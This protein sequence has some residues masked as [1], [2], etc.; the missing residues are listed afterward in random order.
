MTP[1]STSKATVRRTASRATSVCP[2]ATAASSPSPA[3][4]STRSSRSALS[5]TARAGGVTTP[6][7]SSTTP[8]RATTTGSSVAHRPLAL[9]A[10]QPS[11]LASPQAS[12]MPPSKAPWCSP[13]VS[14]TVMVR[15]C[16]TTPATISPTAWS[17]TPT[18]TT[19]KARATAA[20][21]IV[22]PATAPLRTCVLP[23]VRSTAPSRSS[24]V[25]SPPA[26]WVRSRTTPSQPVFVAKPPVA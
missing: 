22:I 23:T 26:S 5:S 14:R 19:P 25:A 3:T 17:S 24:P 8:M 18:V 11:P 7:A 10:Q 16:S 13:G 21:S 15:R 12:R 1:V 6:A 20:S 9:K 2:S 4:G